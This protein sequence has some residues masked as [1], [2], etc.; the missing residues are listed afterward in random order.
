[1]LPAPALLPAPAAIAAGTG[2]GHGQPS[3]DRDGPSCRVWTKLNGLRGPSVT[4]RRRPPRTWYERTNDLRPPFGHPDAE[5]AQVG[6]PNEH[7]LVIGLNLIDQLFRQFGDHLNSIL[8]NSCSDCFLPI[9]RRRPEH[10]G[11]AFGERSAFPAMSL[12]TRTHT[13]PVRKTAP[14]IKGLGQSLTTSYR[15]SWAS[16]QT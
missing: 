8:C 15:P 1:M 3:A 6:V 14:S 13:R 16:P 9:G 10:V 5:I 7:L 11:R 2:R 4:R 12:S